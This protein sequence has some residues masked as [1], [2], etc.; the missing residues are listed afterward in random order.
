MKY[1]IYLI[2]IIVLLGLNLGLFN[3]FQING[4]IPNLLFLFCL[5][6]S[7]EKSAKG[8]SASG[9][10]DY[11]FFFVSF[12]SGLFLDFYSTSFFGGFTLA[13]LCLSFLLHL[14]ATNVIV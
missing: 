2:S 10:I 13:F 9:G 14:M 6:F 7:L 5:C 12:I 11:D 3:N 4:Q 1:L 8:G